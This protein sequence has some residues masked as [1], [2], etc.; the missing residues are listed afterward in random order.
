MRQARVHREFH[1]DIGQFLDRGP[2][3]IRD[4]LADH[5]HIE[6]ETDRGDMPGLFAAEEVTSSAYFQVLHGNGHTGAEVGVLGNGGEPVV[7]GFGERFVRRVEKVR[8]RAFPTTPDTSPQLVQL[9]ETEHV[10]TFHDE[11]VGIGDVEPGFDDRGTDEHVEL[12][13]PERDHHLFEGVLAHLAVGGGDTRLRDELAQPRRGRVDR[14]H[15]VVDEENLALSQQFAP[16]RCGDLPVVARADEG[17]HRVPFLRRGVD[18]RQLP[19]TGD[20]HLQ[21]PGNRGGAHRE[22]VHRGPHLLQVFLVLDAEP[23]LL[24]DYHQAEIL[25]VGR[26]RQQ[27]VGSDD[28][29][30]TALGEP[31]QHSLLLGRGIEP[32]HRPHGHRECRIPLGERLQMLL[33]EQRGR[34]EN[35]DLL[36]VLHRLECSPHRNLGLA[37]ADIA[38]DD[39]VHRD[40][41]AHV[42]LHLLDG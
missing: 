23:L 28:Y 27:P 11:G 9:G 8:I 31:F 19:D 12:L 5:T 2:L 17:E 3:E 25:E 26:G 39:P 35:G 13:F 37:V 24:V 40:G 14:L 41:F 16:D 29:V 1:L 21:R 6:I 36:A 10:G 32:R 38:A 34:D 42:G 33:D 20:R 15:P 18:R 7:R 4:S 30:D 22:H